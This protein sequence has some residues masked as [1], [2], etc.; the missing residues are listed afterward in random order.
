MQS[1]LSK[2]QTWFQWFTDE[3]PTN[4]KHVNTYQARDP[5]WKKIEKL[6]IGG[7]RFFGTREYVERDP[8]WHETLKIYQTR[9]EHWSTF[10]RSINMKDR[11]NKSINRGYVL[12]D[13]AC[14]LNIDVV[15]RSSQQRCSMKKKVI[16]RNFIN[17]QKNTCVG[18][19]LLIKLQ[20]WILQFY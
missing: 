5:G 17:S 19:S 20:T 2:H 7:G 11:R 18:V 8:I 4:L 15:F 16:F 9:L 6:T 12:I 14:A 13:G 1:L 3:I 10:L